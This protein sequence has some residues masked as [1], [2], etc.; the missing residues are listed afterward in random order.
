MSNSHK[1]KGKRSEKYYCKQVFLCSVGRNGKPSP[2]LRVPPPILVSL[3]NLQTWHLHSGSRIAA[4]APWHDSFVSTLFPTTDEPRSHEAGCLTTATHTSIHTHTIR[5]L[6]PLA[7]VCL[8]LNQWRLMVISLFACQARRLP[9][10]T[11]RIASLLRAPISKICPLQV[12]CATHVRLGRL[13]VSKH[14]FGC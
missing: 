4:L 12:L 14:H 2:N 13:K 7:A 6:V 11:T 1:A 8:C 9:N 5:R 10:P 3:T